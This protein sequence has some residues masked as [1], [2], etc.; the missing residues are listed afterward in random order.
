MWD[1]SRLDAEPRMDTA[2][3]NAIPGTKPAELEYVERRKRHGY[4]AFR[5]ALDTA[6]WAAMGFVLVAALFRLLGVI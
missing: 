5:T 6:G 1:T 4:R 2:T 3:F